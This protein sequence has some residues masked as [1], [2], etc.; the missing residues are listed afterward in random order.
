MLEFLLNRKPITLSIETKA[1]HYHD[2]HTKRSVYKGVPH[3]TCEAGKVWGNPIL[4]ESSWHVITLH[5]E[6]GWQE[7]EDNVLLL[8]K[9]LGY[10]YKYRY[11]YA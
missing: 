9:N 7:I 5:E 3:P 6:I 10:D 2:W 11:E 1:T 4:L 8:A